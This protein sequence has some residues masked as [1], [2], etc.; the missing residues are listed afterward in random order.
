M[1]KW[2]DNNSFELISD[3]KLFF[4]Q[5]EKSISVAQREIFLE[6]YIFK[7]DRAGSRIFAALMDAAS[8][9]IKVH[10]VIDGVGSRDFPEVWIRELKKLR[11][12]VH[13]FRPPQKIFKLGGR[14]FRRL[15]R[16]IVTI[17]SHEAFIGGM[18]ISDDQ[19][20]ELDF[21]LLIRGPIC[22]RI[23]RFMKLFF[24]RLKKRWIEYFKELTK[25]PE[26]KKFPKIQRDDVKADF[27]VRDNFRHRRKIENAYLSTM[28][29]AKKSIDIANAYFVPGLRFRNALIQ[30]TGRG[31]QVRLLLQGRTDHPI[32][33]WATRALYDEFVS[34]GI[35]VYE[36]EKKILHAKVAVIDGDW[37][38]V[39]SANLDL[40]SLFLNLEANIIL[41]SLTIGN[42][43]VSVMNQE[44]ETGT[45]Q[46][47]ATKLKQRKLSQRVR[48]YIALGLLKILG[49][50]TSYR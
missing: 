47:T 19:F 21:T 38:T 6:T 48:S 34:H 10:I 17:D 15:H 29:R 50:I 44:I 13:I 16:K 27:V 25:F 4:S 28:S 5:L 41:K 42:A 11:A 24:L 30:A 14:I 20:Q 37:V 2:S 39:G 49:L 7:P 35:Q 43:I 3:A 26:S 22:L 9:G 31:I 23:H 8:R 32:V 36:Y 46:I 45:I 40:F 33:R 18:N 1:T 12:R